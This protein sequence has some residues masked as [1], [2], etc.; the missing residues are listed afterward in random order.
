MFIDRYDA[1]QQLVKKLEKFRNK[2]AIIIAIPRGGVPLAY[3][4]SKTLNLPLEIFL[5]KKIGHP[6][7]PE[8]AIGSVTL[9][10][11]MLDD[12]SNDVSQDYLKT[13]IDR[14]LRSL[15]E[16]FILF[17]GDRKPIDLKNKTVI[18]VDDGIATGNTIQATV[19]VIKK[20]KPKKI[21]ISVPVAPHSATKKFSNKVDEFIC[22]HTPKDF[23]GV[24]QYFERFPQIN[25]QEVIQLLTDANKES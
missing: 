19:D 2:N 4:I 3:Y 22:L 21:I 15:K 17:M 18:I 20:N 11:V 25:D 13:E 23:I 9:N 24:G 7:N 6:N 16:K 1:A 8:F 5:S 14:I 12:T 10:G